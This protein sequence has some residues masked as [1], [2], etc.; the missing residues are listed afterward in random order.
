MRNRRKGNAMIETAMFVPLFILLLVGTV[1]LARVSWIYFQA[2]KTLYNLGRLLGTRQGANLC[3]SADAEV[4]SARNF[5]LTGSSEGG[6]PLIR[7]LTADVI[8]V[9]LERQEA[10]SESATEC[11]C[12]LEGCDTG[13]G[14]RGP[15]FIV[16][17]VPEGFPVPVSIPYLLPQT[18][19]MRLSVRVPYGGS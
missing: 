5:A 19:T 15:D 10:N 6:E 8:S 4:V 1:E 14:G 16:V 17:S 13:Q 3:D 2:Q 11:A 9:R 12:S 18:I 7:G